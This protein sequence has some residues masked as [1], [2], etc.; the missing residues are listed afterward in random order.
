MSTDAFLSMFG[1]REAHEP[2]DP[3][4]AA[5]SGMKAALPKRFY[6]RA[7]I[8]GGEGGFRLLLDGKPALTPGRRPLPPQAAPSQRR[9]PPNGARRASA[10]IRPTCR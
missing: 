1:A 6:E 3:M 2:R 7:S 9:S 10:S 5:Q 4:K 8:R